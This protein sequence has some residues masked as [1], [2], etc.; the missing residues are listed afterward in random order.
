[1]N[2]P[3]I[4]IAGTQSGAGKTSLTL[5]LVTL[6]RRRGLRVQTFKVGPD[7]LDPTYLTLAS[8]RSCY[9]LDGW[10]TSES[11]VKQLF[12]RAC[13]DANIAVVEGVMGLFDGADPGS[14]EGS[15]AEMAR[16]LDAPVVLVADVQGMARSL[17]AVVHGYATFDRG[18]RIAGVIANRCGSERHA[19]W[20][21]ES[22]RTAS[23]PPLLGGVKRD[24]LPQLPSRHLGLVTA[25]TARISQ[26]LL[27]E[28]ADALAPGILLDDLITK[29]GQASSLPDY[30]NASGTLAPLSQRPRL[31]VAHDE[32]FHFYYPD[33][34]EALEAAGCELIR[35][36]PLRD[37]ALPSDLNGLYLGG[38]YPEEH[39]A[40]LAANEAMLDA[41]RLFASAGGLIYAECG[42]LMYL[43]EGIETLDGTRHRL[44]RLLPVWTRMCRQRQSLGYVEV[45][46]T[47]DSLWGRRGQ[48][49]RGHEFHYSELLGNPANDSG[50]RTVYEASYRRQERPVREGFQRGSILA[51][52]VHLH[53]ASRPEAVRHFVERL[54]KS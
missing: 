2:I 30:S 18:L 39:A 12:V 46:L 17:A 5:G 7:Y 28:L 38:G 53:F 27:D 37:R 15:T 6:L 19:Q 35:F 29:A 24:A 40:A 3:R 10:M 23:L 4:V 42:G 34:L 14:S 13:R 48:T 11:Y 8:G 43:A 31:G 1:M 9:N 50:W 33:N 22:L 36:S 54:A 49:L 41:V 20:L 51:S 52:Y 16:W 32:A 44:A 26:E 47:E 45:A 21:A 25:E